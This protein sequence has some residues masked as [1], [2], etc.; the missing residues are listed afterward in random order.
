MART[1]VN[2]E[3]KRIQINGLGQKNDKVE[4]LV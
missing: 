1:E 3:K 4:S 2:L